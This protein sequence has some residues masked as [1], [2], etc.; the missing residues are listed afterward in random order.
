MD[1][2]RTDLAN[3]TAELNRI[4]AAVWKRYPGV[5]PEDKALPDFMTNEE[6]WRWCTVGVTVEEIKK[7]L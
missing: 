2:V 1:K 7:H 5:Y 3:A 4:K 6:Y